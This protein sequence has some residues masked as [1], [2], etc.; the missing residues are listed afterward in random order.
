MNRG[1]LA[2]PLCGSLCDLCASVVSVFVRIFTTETQRT[3][4]IHGEIV[5]PTRADDFF[6]SLLDLQS[7]VAQ[8]MR[9]TAYRNGL[10]I[11]IFCLLCLLSFGCKQATALAPT[12]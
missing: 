7:L 6:S 8:S 11:R 12:R 5:N 9:P 4:E 3:T 2:D 10:T 1:A